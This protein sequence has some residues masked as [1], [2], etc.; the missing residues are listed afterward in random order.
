[1]SAQSRMSLTVS[2]DPATW[3]LI[4]VRSRSSRSV[5]SSVKSTGL[6]HGSTPSCHPGLIW[7][8]G[9]FMRFAIASRAFA[10]AALRVPVF[11]VGFDVPDYVDLILGVNGKTP[12]RVI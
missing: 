11:S 9:F 1:M 2:H 6:G 4:D 7:L 8:A 12:C 10:L 3:S 5:T